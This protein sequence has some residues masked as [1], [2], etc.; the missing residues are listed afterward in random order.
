MIRNVPNRYTRYQI[1]DELNLHQFEGCYD[2]VYLPIDQATE[3][4]VGYAFVNFR[5]VQKNVRLRW[6]LGTV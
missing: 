1:V 4:N 5:T 3:A 6:Q 2:F